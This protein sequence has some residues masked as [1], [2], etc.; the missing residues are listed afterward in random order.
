MAH[1]EANVQIRPATASDEEFI[2]SL[3]PR[4]VEFGVPAWRDSAQMIATDRQVLRDKLREQ[5]QGSAI[6]IAEDE[7]G[8]ALGLIHLQPGADYYHRE[9]HGHIADLIVAA[10]GEGRGVGRRLMA[11]A[12][13]W[14]R[15]RGFGWLTLSVFADNRRARELYTRLGFGEDI[16]KYVKPLDS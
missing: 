3:A 4:L 9:P 13:E 10:A 7:R 6:F 14:A 11:A 5:P 15:A 2:L 12:E 8:V 16:I 1:M